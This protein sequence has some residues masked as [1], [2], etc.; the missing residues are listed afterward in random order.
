MLRGNISNLPVSKIVKASFRCFPLS[1]FFLL[2][3]LYLLHNRAKIYKV[4][5]AGQQKKILLLNKKCQG[6]D[7]GFVIN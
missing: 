7:T 6:V 1:D 2:P 5:S 3:T 4:R